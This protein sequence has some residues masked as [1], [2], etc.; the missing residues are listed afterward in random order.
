DAAGPHS[1]RRRGRMRGLQPLL[2]GL[3]GGRLHHDGTDRYRTTARIMGTARGCGGQRRNSVNTVIR[4]GTVVTARETKVADVRIE[5]GRIKEVGPNLPAN[6]ADKVIDATGMYVMPG[7]ID[8]HTHLDMP[9]GGTMS[10][11]DF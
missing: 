9:F 10:A 3:P 7:G 2:A 8:A 4:N 1:P 6:S 11:D 5:G